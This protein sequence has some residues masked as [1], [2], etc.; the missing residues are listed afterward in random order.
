MPRKE[1]APWLQGVLDALVADNYVQFLDAFCD[2]ECPKFL[3]PAE[4]SFTLD[5]TV[6]HQQYQRL[7]ES[8]IEAH[9]RKA[10]VDQ[11]T[12]MEALVADEAKQLDA[13]SQ[14]VQDLE[15]ARAQ[16][17]EAGITLAYSSPPPVQ[18]LIASLVAVQDFERFAQMMLQRALENE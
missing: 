18:S 14:H 17:A 6:V 9:L 7:Y 5:Q 3:R 8:R 15:T 10:N 11:A 12:F 1:R 4:D 16:A 13:Q 2:R